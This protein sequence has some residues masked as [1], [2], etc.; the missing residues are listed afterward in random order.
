MPSPTDHPSHAITYVKLTLVALMW[1]A[2]FIAGRYIA[3]ILEPLPAATARFGAA[4]L[5][6]V[7]LCILRE[8][9]LPRLTPKQLIV[10][11]A[12]GATG[13]YTY[14]IT[15]FGALA[16]MPASRTAIFVALNPITVALVS[17]AIFGDRFT[18]QRILGTLIAL[19]GAAI[20]VSRGDLLALLTDITST[21]GKGEA[22]MITAVFAWAFYTVIGRFALSSISPLATTTYAAIFG[23]IM[24][25]ITTIFWGPESGFSALTLPGIAAVLYLAIGGTVIPFVWYYQGV[26]TIGPAR[27]AIFTNLVPVFGVAL[28]ALLL[29]ET[30]LPSMIL[31]GALV[32]LGVSLTNRG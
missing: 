20:V 23:W 32:I 30:I 17:A 11:I 25:V 27:S 15:F 7:A 13:V 10:M 12:L 19:F 2:T 24:L 22:L 9:R 31:G 3:P 5:V 28:G 29:G 18:P 1:G 14:N 8:G 6:L 16:E 21:L 4:T 26:Q